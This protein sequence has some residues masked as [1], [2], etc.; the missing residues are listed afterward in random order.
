[1]PGFHY[2]FRPEVALYTQHMVSILLGDTLH[3]G[4]EGIHLFQ[5][6]MATNGTVL[7]GILLIVEI[8]EM[9]GSEDDIVSFRN[10]FHAALCSSPRHHRGIRSQ[11]AFQNLVPTD[12]AFSVVVCKAFHAAYHIALK[13]FHVFQPFGLH[14]CLAVG[15]DGPT[16]LSGFVSTYVD[17]FARK[18]FKDL[19]QHIL[20]E[21]ICA[22]LTGA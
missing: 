15:T 5:R 14:A 20:Q 1:M 18:H 8:A 21:R 6:Q 13:L 19:Q 10:G 2:P 9:C 4:V 11:S 22:L 17:V 16:L 12:Y 3:Y 7:C